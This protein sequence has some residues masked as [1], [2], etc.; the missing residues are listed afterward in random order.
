MMGWRLKFLGSLI[1]ILIIILILPGC[2]TRNSISMVPGPMDLDRK[3]TPVFGK[4]IRIAV[5][6]DV[7]KINIVSKNAFFTYN[8]TT[9][10]LPS[11]ST[12]EI[13][14]KGYVLINDRSFPAPV[15]VHS[16]ENLILN[17][18]EYYGEII[19]RDFLVINVLPLEE[20]LKGVLSS[21]VAENWPFE[22]LKAQAIVSRTYALNRMLYSTNSPYDL[23][24][25]EIH[26]KFQYRRNNSRIN[27]AIEATEGTIIPVIFFKKIFPISEVH[28]IP[29]APKT[30]GPSEPPL[31]TL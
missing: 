25:S 19:I 18:K 17:G 12:L 10:S 11:A 9:H 21:E 24:D 30:S 7:K 27:E 15:A 6:K 3:K 29:I 26:Q 23:E 31:I 16:E 22:A 28:P 14:N 13:I 20:Y 8:G 4:Y 5:E 1:L 2:I